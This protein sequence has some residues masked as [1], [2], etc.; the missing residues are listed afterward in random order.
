MHIT[1]TSLSEWEH[2]ST[3]CEHTFLQTLSYWCEIWWQ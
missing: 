2:Q 3:L 1:E